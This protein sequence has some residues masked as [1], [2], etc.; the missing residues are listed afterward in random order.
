MTREE[1]L[2]NKLRDCIIKKDFVGMKRARQE[3]DACLKLNRYEHVSVQQVVME[4]SE[5]DRNSLLRKLN[6]IPV[7][8][9]LIESLMVD[10]VEELKRHDNTI[11]MKSMTPEVE[12]IKKAASKIRELMNS[13]GVEAAIQFG[14]LC[15]RV[16]LIIDNEFCMAEARAKKK[17]A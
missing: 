3:L 6:R 8:A 16:K 4:M 5:K 2:R 14:E 12:A 13:G 17:T 11:I 10:F 9:D 15:D 7:M 1:T